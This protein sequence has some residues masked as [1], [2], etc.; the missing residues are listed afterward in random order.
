MMAFCPYCGNNWDYNGKQET[1]AT[2]PNCKKKVRL[3]P[4]KRK[5]F[6]PYSTLHFPNRNYE[7]GKIIFNP[8]RRDDVTIKYLFPKLETEGN[9]NE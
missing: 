2:C 8:S 7:Y 5:N 3:R 6:K 4:Y 1:Y 9:Q